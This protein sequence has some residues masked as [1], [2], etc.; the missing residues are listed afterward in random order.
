MF[1]LLGRQIDEIEARI[2]QVDAKLNAAHKASE[3]SQRLVTIPGVGPVT[4][5]TLAVEIDPGDVRIRTPSRRMGRPHAEGTFDRWQ[6]TNGRH[7][8]GRQ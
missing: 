2:K 3:V 6:T 1:V 8:P 7:Q 5:L 4:A